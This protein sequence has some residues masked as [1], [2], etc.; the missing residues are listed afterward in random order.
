ML[1]NNQ[2]YD[3]Y[4]GI[5]LLDDMHNYFPD[6]LYNPLRFNNVQ[7]VL[8]YIPILDMHITFFQKYVYI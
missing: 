1:H 3:P 7:D 2:Q 5:G 4:Y 6:L 8:N